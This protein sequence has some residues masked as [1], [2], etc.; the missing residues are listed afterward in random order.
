M[1]LEAHARLADLRVHRSEPDCGWS[2][3]FQAY[4]VGQRWFWMSGD[5]EVSTLVPVSG[6]PYTISEAAF[7]AYLE[8]TNEH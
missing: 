6:M 2:S 1:E 5:Q 7:N 3:V 4:T 8:L